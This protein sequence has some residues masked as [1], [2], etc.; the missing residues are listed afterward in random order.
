VRAVSSRID[1]KTNTEDLASRIDHKYS[2]LASAAVYHPDGVYLFVALE[3]SR[4]V[5]V[6]DSVG[7]KEL[8]RFQ[9]GRAPQGLAVSGDG[10]TLYVNNFM[11]R[12]VSAID[13]TPLINSGLG[14]AP[15]ITTWSAV[16]A[17]KL[18]ADVLDGKQLFYDARDPRMAR[19]GYLSCATC[20][21]DGGHDGRVW[22]FTSLG[23]GLRN[24]IRLRGRGGIKQGYL[25]WSANFDEGQ[26]FEG[27]I[28]SLA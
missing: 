2:G 6:I 28:R 16:G 7:K 14:T 11:D 27:Q 4:E 8:V 13:L 21:D 22:D 3:T 5:D 17:E 23:E 26:D 24:T 10:K 1:L 9:V 12:T 15:P 20:H 18:A 19:D 25:H